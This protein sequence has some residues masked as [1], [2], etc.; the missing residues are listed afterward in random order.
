R[1]LK[2]TVLG[3]LNFYRKTGGKVSRAP[4]VE[5]LVLNR[6]VFCIFVTKCNKQ[7]PLL[8]DVI[9]SSIKINSSR[10]Q[11]LALPIKK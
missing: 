10:E 2:G 8:D 5:G 7:K 9:L 4:V 11:I 1:K 3:C 6:S